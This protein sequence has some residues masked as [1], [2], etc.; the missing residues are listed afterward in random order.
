MW[1]KHVVVA[2]SFT[3]STAPS[4]DASE[5][6]HVLEL[7]H[8]VVALTKPSEGFFYTFNCSWYSRKWTKASRASN[9]G[10][11]KLV[12]SRVESNRKKTRDKEWEEWK[13]EG[14]E[15][16]R[17]SSR[18]STSTKRI[19]PPPLSSISLNVCVLHPELG[20]EIGEVKHQVK[21]GIALTKVYH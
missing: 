17:A 13:D 1:V 9:S 21:H 16:E 3:L 8:V 15:W 7:K 18:E 19:C 14:R 11:Q 4:T 20:G 6:K 2:L 10:H 5:V 12:I